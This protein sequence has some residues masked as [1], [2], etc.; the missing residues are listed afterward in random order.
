MYEAW[1]VP[2]KL[3]SRAL[4]TFQSVIEVTVITLVLKG[5]SHFQGDLTVIVTS[6]DNRHFS[7]FSALI[8]NA[9]KIL[10]NQAKQML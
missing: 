5:A 7:T 10:F 4:F 8:L 6:N 2:S 9:I 1:I 3:N